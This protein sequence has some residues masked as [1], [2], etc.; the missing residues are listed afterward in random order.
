MDICAAIADGFALHPLKLCGTNPR[1]STPKRPSTPTIIRNILSHLRW[2]T[3]GLPHLDRA[4]TIDSLKVI[5][6]RKSP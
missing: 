3:V 5:E 4:V 2:F 1:R 6:S